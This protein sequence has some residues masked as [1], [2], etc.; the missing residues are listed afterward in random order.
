MTRA[1]DYGRK[2]PASGV[3]KSIVVFLHGYGA[4]GAD[5][6][7]LADPLAP[8]LPD[9]EFLAPDAPE[10]CVGNPFGRQW[11]PIPWL[12]GSSEAAA[13]AGLESS[14]SDLNA[15]LDARL[16]EAGLSPRSLALVGFSQGAMMSLH[17]A[18]RRSVA[19]AGIVAI[20]GRLLRPE[21]LATEAVVK[22]PVLLVHGD[23]DPV[24]PFEDMGKAG[25][26][27]VGAGFE[28]YGHVMK[29]TG[30][31]IAPDGLSVARSFLKDRLPA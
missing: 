8:H 13:A 7:G 22:P 9:T 2:G 21:L 31:G 17:V 19:I 29:G 18:P 14:S 6:L 20:S 3:T 1:L 10:P 28:T 16:E 26:A 30:H 12:D 15:F 25:N 24:V 27:L 5:L 4:D 11:F 23:A